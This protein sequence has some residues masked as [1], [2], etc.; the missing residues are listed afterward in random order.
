MASNI[1]ILLASS[2]QVGLHTRRISGG[3]AVALLTLILFS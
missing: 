1:A 2:S 3:L